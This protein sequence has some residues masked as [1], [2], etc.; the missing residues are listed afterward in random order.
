MMQEHPVVDRYL[1]RLG[2]SLND[3][4]VSERAAIIYAACR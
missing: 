1:S 4:D 3:I 2:V